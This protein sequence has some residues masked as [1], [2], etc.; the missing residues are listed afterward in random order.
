MSTE[1]LYQQ[2]EVLI[3]LTLLG[4]LAL[5]GEIGYRVA[6]RGSQRYD[7]ST[8]SQIVSIQA[9]I[10][11]LLSLILGFTFSM[12]LSRFE[13]RK[14]MVVEEAN[15][16]GTVALRA[17]FLPTDH[18]VDVRA[19][20][21]RYVEIR[22]YSVLQTAQSSPERQQLDIETRQLQSQL[23]QI[24]GDASLQEPQSVPLGLFTQAVNNLID[25]KAKRDTGVANHVPEIVLLLLMGFAL[26][27][28]GVLTYGNGLTGAR[29]PIPTAAYSI[30]VVLVVLLIIDLDHPQSG[31]ARVSQASIIQIQEILN[32][33]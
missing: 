3:A 18:K 27:A 10:L 28:M 23:W 13:Y 33:R 12:A 26:L 1:F 7:E 24:A 19:L 15:A 29:S 17:Q 30:V 6:R 25:V 4:F 11:G 5:A 2:S 14:Q 9:A 31:V 21:R 8:R 32:S 22:L 16:I 20:L